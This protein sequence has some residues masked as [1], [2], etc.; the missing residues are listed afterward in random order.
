ME[1]PGAE[2]GCWMGPGPPSRM[3]TGGVSLLVRGM[4]ESWKETVMW[5]LN[6]KP[7]KIILD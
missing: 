5:M 7:H 3:R 4:G 1:E 6:I 2:L